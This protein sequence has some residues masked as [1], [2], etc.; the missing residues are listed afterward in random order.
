MT[1]GEMAK[2]L[3]MQH[4]RGRW[5]VVRWIEENINRW[6][7]DYGDYYAELVESVT[8]RASP[9]V[10]P[11][12]FW[13]AYIVEGGKV[14]SVSFPQSLDNLVEEYAEPRKDELLMLEMTHPEDFNLMVM[15]CHQL[16]HIFGRPHSTE[17]EYHVAREECSGSG[18]GGS[19]G[20]VNYHRGGSGEWEFYCG[21]SPRCCP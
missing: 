13:L 8:V 21:G 4:H 17:L 10:I 12:G 15:F 5:P 1:H 2:L 18:C 11:G 9:G 3:N 14:T 6:H 19:M 7:P 20:E 16:D